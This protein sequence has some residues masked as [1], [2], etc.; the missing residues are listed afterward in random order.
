MAEN[1]RLVSGDGG[2][3]RSGAGKRVA[4]GPS[5]E[6]DQ[7]GGIRTDA[8]PEWRELFLEVRK[9]VQRLRE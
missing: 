6:P 4:D 7:A 5:A 3:G 8:S 1:E 2:A 9:A